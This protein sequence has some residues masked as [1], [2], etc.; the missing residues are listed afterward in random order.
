MIQ[1]LVPSFFALW[2]AGLVLLPINWSS[3]QETA[4]LER[5]TLPDTD[6]GLAGEGPIRRYDW[7]KNL[8]QKRRS[9]FAARAA[10]EHGAVVFLGDS[11]TQGWGDRFQ[12]D[13]G[14]LSVANRGISGDTTRGMLIRLD[15]DV[16][17]LDPS[18]VVMLM[19][20]N[21]LEEQAEPPTIASALFWAFSP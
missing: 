12:G 20:T 18:G 3:A 21:D 8:W 7:F 9:E 16:L 14:D 17:S 1:T 2:F 4:T 13:F 15:Q 19:G 6:E 11:I 10:Q 5:F